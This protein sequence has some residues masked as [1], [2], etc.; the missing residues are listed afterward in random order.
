M[1][2][3]SLRMGKAKT[4][5]RRRNAV[6]YC[7]RAPAYQAHG[8]HAGSVSMAMAASTCSVPDVSMICRRRSMDG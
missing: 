2:S 5:T 8:R 7:W 3:A 4:S 6:V 1:R